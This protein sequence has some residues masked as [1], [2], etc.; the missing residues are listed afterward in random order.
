M[1]IRRLGSVFNQAIKAGIIKENP[2]NLFDRRE[3][4]MYIKPE[5]PY[6]TLDDVKLLKNTPCAFP[7]I[8]EAYLF[9]CYTSLRF[10]D[11]KALTWGDFRQDNNNKTRL[12]YRQKKTQKQEYLPLA[13]PTLDILNAREHKADTE[14]VFDL[15]DNRKSIKN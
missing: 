5:I 4:P 10:S 1:Y 15:Q 13:K 2:L 8:K 6:L 3:L 7:E 11:V 14:P 12:A 9:S